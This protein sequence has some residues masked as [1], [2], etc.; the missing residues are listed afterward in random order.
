LAPNYFDIPSD[1]KWA[2]TFMDL[3]NNNVKTV[4]TN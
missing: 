3:Y 4:V 2:S 1:S